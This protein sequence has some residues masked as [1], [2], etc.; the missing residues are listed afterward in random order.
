MQRIL[1]IGLPQR[2]SGSPEHQGRQ[3]RQSTAQSSTIL[4]PRITSRRSSG[5]I[6]DGAVAAT[7]RDGAATAMA[8]IGDGAATA[9]AGIG[10]GAAADGGGGRLLN[11]RL[12]YG[13]QLARRG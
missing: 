12:A 4:R 5:V 10:D 11:L 1:L 9:M 6:G 2:A 3:P 13:V 7:I 8:G